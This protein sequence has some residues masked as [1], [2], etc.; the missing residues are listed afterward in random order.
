MSKI[1]FECPKYVLNV[2]ELVSNVW[3]MFCMTQNLFWKSR[4]L[5]WMSKISFESWVLSNLAEGLVKTPA[6]SKIGNWQE[7]GVWATWPVRSCLVKC[8][9]EGIK[10]AASH[11]GFGHG[12]LITRSAEN[13][14]INET[15]TRQ[16]QPEIPTKY[17]KNGH[18]LAHGMS[19]H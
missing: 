11:S 13:T 10:L 5:F 12:R 14:T 19:E 3:N 17:Y 18:N 4:N 2:P 1:S 15:S 9:P 16:Q 8:Q 7:G 6:E